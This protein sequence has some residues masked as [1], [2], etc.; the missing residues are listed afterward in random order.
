MKNMLACAA[1]AAS[2][3]AVIMPAHAVDGV[4]EINQAKATAAGGFPYVISQPGSYRLTSNLVQPDVNTDVI[5]IEA[6]NVTLDLNGFSIT[7]ANQ[8]TWSYGHPHSVTC[9]QNGAGRGL[10]SGAA[11]RRISVANGTVAGM[12]GHGIYLLGNQSYLER[13]HVR[14]SGATGIYISSGQVDHVSSE[15]NASDGIT[16]ANGSVT[17]AI[18]TKNGGVGILAHGNVADSQVDFN[19]SHGINSFEGVV[20]GNQAAYNSGV[21]MLVYG[22][23]VIGNTIVANEGVGLE[24]AGGYVRY[25]DNMIHAN[26]NGGSQ[27]TV[28]SNLLN[29]GGNFCNSVACP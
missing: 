26:N 23:N 1:A 8:C 16:S 20:S 18:S 9:T 22:A 21:G 12:S 25:G 27:I 6:S 13:V 24:E 28:S 7:G 4:I 10:Y 19:V 29:A 3:V 14:D 2:F 17:N 15:S 5:R 11:Y